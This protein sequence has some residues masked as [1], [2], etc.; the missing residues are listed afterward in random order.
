MVFRP[1]QPDGVH[2]QS[3]AA[4][5]FHAFSVISEAERKIAGRPIR[6][7]ASERLR[8]RDSAYKLPATPGLLDAASAGTVPRQSAI[9]TNRTEGKSFT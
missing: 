4:R 5:Q 1:A 2:S 6:R 8:G 3:T 7:S 9:H